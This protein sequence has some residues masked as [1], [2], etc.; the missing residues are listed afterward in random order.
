MNVTIPMTPSGFSRLEQELRKLKSEDRPA[1]IQ[2]IAEA[3]AHGDLSENAEYHAAKDKQGFIEARIKDLEAKVSRA[4]IID[5]KDLQGNT[6]IKFSATVTVVDEDTD[7]EFEY[8]IV[9]DDE[10]NIRE[11]RIAF[12]S[13]LGRALI[14]KT[15]GDSVEVITP[16]GDKEYEILKVEYAE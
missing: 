3:R 13:P 7:Q 1:V 10:A 14:G 4:K 6:T 11:G 8:Q 5:P 15:A 16:N 2:A 9:G 12:S